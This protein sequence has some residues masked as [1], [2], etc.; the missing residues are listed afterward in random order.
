MPRAEKRH[1]SRQSQLDP[2]CKITDTDL[3]LEL[4]H[5]PIQVLRQILPSGGL[6]LVHC[7]FGS[8]LEAIAVFCEGSLDEVD[9]CVEECL[10]GI[11]ARRI[12]VPLHEISIRQRSPNNVK[13]LAN[14]AISFSLMR[15]SNEAEK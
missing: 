15:R 13:A 12:S 10:D 4:L 7:L 6:H 2:G 8:N 11:Y 14:S 3:E 5:L 9:A 1:P